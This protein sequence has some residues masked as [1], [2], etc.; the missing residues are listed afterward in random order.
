MPHEKDRGGRLRGRKGTGARGGGGRRE[1]DEGKDRGSG[2]LG[3]GGGDGATAGDERREH[4]EHACTRA[5]RSVP[6][7]PIRYL[8]AQFS[9]PEP[10]LVPSARIS[11]VG[12]TLVS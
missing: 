3:E 2:D 10:G 8:R 6:Q 1:T 5:P 12:P 4:R 11:T 9:T 7:S